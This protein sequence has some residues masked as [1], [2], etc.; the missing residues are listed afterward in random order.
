MVAH[1][2]HVQG[3]KSSILVAV[4]LFLI[5]GNVCSEFKSRKMQSQ[6]V[7]AVV[8]RVWY[9]LIPTNLGQV[10]RYDGT[11]KPRFLGKA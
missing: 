10:G 7:V 5:G 2:A 4:F 11:I 9:K 3:D 8:D 1:T 6:A